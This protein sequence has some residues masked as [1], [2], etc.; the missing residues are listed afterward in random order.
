MAIF[1][2]TRCHILELVK[3]SVA[4]AL[5][6]SIGRHFLGNIQAKETSRGRQI[7]AIQYLS[8]RFYFVTVF[9][10]ALFPGW[11]AVRAVNPTNES[12]SPKFHPGRDS[13]FDYLLRIYTGVD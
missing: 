1:F 9:F 8:H 13:A 2:F 5:H 10:D 11:I 7:H 12:P 4:V 6:S 3:L